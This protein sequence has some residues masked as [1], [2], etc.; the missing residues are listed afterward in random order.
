MA[1]LTIHLSDHAVERFQQRVRPALALP[2]AREE[3]VHLALVAELATEP[4][5]WHAACCAQL[6]PWYLVIGD[7]VLPLK[8][9]WAEPDALIATTCLARGERSADVRR[10]RRDGRHVSR[11]RS[12]RPAIA[13]AA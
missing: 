5:A 8:P 11:R 7:V 13:E 9:H 4:P 6:A 1:A 12:R 3:L 10:R 2:D